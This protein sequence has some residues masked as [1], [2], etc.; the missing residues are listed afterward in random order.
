M[1]K[2]IYR[3]P[4]ADARE[5]LGRAPIVHVATTTRSG[6]PLLRTVHAVVDDD[7]LLFHGAPAGEKMEGLGREA[8][9]SADEI[10]ASIPSWFVDPDRACPATTYYLSAQAHGTLLA[11][12]DPVK[13]ARVLAALMA[14]YQ[15][16]GRHEPIASTHP[17]YRKAIAGLLVCELRFE[18][19][20]AKAKLG[21][22]RRPEERTR[23][24]EHLWRRGAPG[25]VRAIAT[26][27]ARSPDLPPPFFLHGPSPGITLCCTVEGAAVGEAARLLEDA[28][29]LQG[30]P[31]EELARAI[32]RSP[33]QVGARDGQGRLVGFARATSDG[34][35]AWIYDVVIAEHARGK[36]I[37]SAVLKLLLD[38]PDVRAA[39]HVRLGTR[40]AMG[41]YRRFGFTEVASAPRHPWP[42]TEMIRARG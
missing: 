20:S 6:S 42:T 37:G 2:A 10:V 40:D 3:A 33:A 24:L 21:Q 11:V 16:E 19:L 25:D 17:L 7:G 30:H 29:W 5:L 22:N 31:R 4:E 39:R 36:G 1:R 27:L 34:R 18:R 32:T 15:P 35:V 12:D 8:V 28:Y 23:I 13:K 26:L 14:K 9:A 41:F 38:H